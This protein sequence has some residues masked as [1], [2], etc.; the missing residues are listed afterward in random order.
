MSRD[1]W[2]AILA[3]VPL[4]ATAGA[5]TGNGVHFEQAVE[6]NEHEWDA[7]PPMKSVAR[8]RVNPS[9]VD[10]TGHRVGRLTVLGMARDSLDPKG[11]KGSL[12]VCRCVCGRYVGRRSKGL[13]KSPLVLM[14]QKCAY[15]AKLREAASGSNARQRAES[16]EARKWTSATGSPE[17]EEHAA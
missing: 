6:P 8:Y 14:C 12:W 4:N 11:N 13:K 5:V 9:F 10:F 3:S 7:P 2:D 16:P 17:S 15:T 1:H